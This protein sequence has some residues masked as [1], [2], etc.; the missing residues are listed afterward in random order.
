MSRLAA[1]KKTLANKDI[2]Q[3]IENFF[4]LAIL[5][6]FNL[7]LPFVTLPYLI[8]TLGFEQ[9]GAIVLAL[10]LM[11]YFQAV[12]DY[13]FNL[14]ATRDIA[15]HRHSKQQLS[16]IYSKVM[17]SKL[18][19]LAISISLILPVIFLV[20][21]FQT[22][23][24]VFLLMLPVLIGHTLFPEWFFRGEE[25]MR[26]ITVLDLSIKLFF[27]AG[28]FVFIHKPEDYWIYPLLNGVGY[29]VVAVVAHYLVN[30]HFSTSFIAVG[31]RQTKT[32]L[33]N[34]FP[35]FVNQFAPNLYNNTTDFLIG[36][37]LGNYS[38]GVFGAVRRVT[39]LLSVFNSVVISVFYPYLN[40]NFK[41]F[42]VFSK[43]YLTFYL[44]FSICF[45]F[46]LNPMFDFLGIQDNNAL[47]VGVLLIIGLY[48][49]GVNNVYATNY[50]VIVGKD[51]L[52]M[53]IT[54]I[55]SLLGMVLGVMLVVNFGMLGGSINIAV[56]QFLLGFLA[57]YYYLKHK[58]KKL[59]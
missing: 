53:T 30:K 28:V 31:V 5:K 32:T 41:K 45:V 37:V 23:R 43:L 17:A 54:T 40:R 19:L 57:F 24:A 8:K 39:D 51:F 26:Y 56:I 29:C 7:I 2:K 58:G 36:L 59:L 22:D 48:F 4:S 6:V 42:S 27:T 55:C 15:R 1:V 14:S 11:Q 16:F 52:V 25:K 3:L 12:T 46:S 18:V 13:G 44:V 35:L 49:R 9:Y 10:A 34:S 21:Q 50:L 33:K 38:A 20:P 47:T